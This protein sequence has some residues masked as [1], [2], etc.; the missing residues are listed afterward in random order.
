MKSIF[1][2]VRLM[3]APLV[4][5]RLVAL[6]PKSLRHIALMSWVPVIMSI[7]L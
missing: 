1:V 6:L 4:I 3:V 5:S 2:V 7:A